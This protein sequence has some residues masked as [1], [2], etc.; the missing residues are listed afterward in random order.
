VLNAWFTRSENAANFKRVANP[1][2]WFI[3]TVQRVTRQ[4]QP[5]R[6]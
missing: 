2:L 3:W 4:G 5:K 1:W 6:S